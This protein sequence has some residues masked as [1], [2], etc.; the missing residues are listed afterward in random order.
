MT[1]TKEYIE[2][3]CIDASDDW[4]MENDGTCSV[5]IYGMDGTVRKFFGDP[6]YP[7]SWVDSFAIVDPQQERV[8]SID[9]VLVTN[10]SDNDELELK[11]MIT[12]PPEQ[13]ALYEML[14]NTGG[15]EFRDFIESC[16]NDARSFEMEREG[17]FIDI[18]ED[19]LEEKGIRI[20]SS[21]QEM[22]DAEDDPENNNARIYGEDYDKLSQKIAALCKEVL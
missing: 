9:N 8:I 17:T 15:E 5:G 21:D 4:Q 3:M 14:Q 19:F 2:K 20:P 7:D 12:N 13:K 1:F 6:E 11:I 22:L 10:D 18:F 16:K